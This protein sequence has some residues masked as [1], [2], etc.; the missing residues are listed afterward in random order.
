MKNKK[1]NMN[2]VQLLNRMFRERNSSDSTRSTYW[3]SVNYFENLTNHDIVECLE[4]A[5]TEEENNIRWK[6]CHLRQWLIQY[7]EWCYENYKIPTAK[8]Y[9]TAIITLFRHFEVTVE[10][11]PYYSTK[12]A[13]KSIPINPDKL[14]DREILKLCINTSN[15]LLRAIVLLMSSSGISRIDTLNLTIQDYLNAT[16]TT[17]LTN[18]P[19][20]T[21]PTWTLTRQKTGQDYYTFSSPESTTAINAYLLTRTNIKPNEPLF[22]VHERYFSDLFKLRNDELGLG[23]NGEY[24]RFAPHMLRRYHATQLI[25]AGLSVDKVNILQ[26]RK[27]QG[28]AYESYV[29]IKPS[30]LKQ[31]YIHALPYLV[32]E[33]VN[34]YKT[35]NEVLREE[36]TVLKTRYDRIQADIDS[37]EAR[38][39]AWE[40]LQKK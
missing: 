20:D 14:V 16:N 17:Q 37:I 38:M 29:K 11:L 7:R 32:V 18:I 30:R 35:E 4:I 25:E 36:N 21:I 33:D 26:G 12:Q 8:L 28:I 15:P 3:R 1:K 31:E 9:L 27:P 19:N 6:N 13:T 39:N 23:R 40:E 34:K 10:H 5:E 22:K 24:R 2:K